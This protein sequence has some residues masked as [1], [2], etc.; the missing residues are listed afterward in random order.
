M[1]ILAA[2][3]P[4]EFTVKKILSKQERV[5]GFLRELLSAE[6]R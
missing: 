2:E 1:V 5:I 3:Q 4:V 6:R